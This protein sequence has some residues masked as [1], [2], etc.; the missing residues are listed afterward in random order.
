MK[1]ERA[2]S[3]LLPLFAFII[4]NILMLE[5]ASL[6][7]LVLGRAVSNDFTKIIRP[8]KRGG[9]GDGTGESFDIVAC[10]SLVL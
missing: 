6:L 9:G 4:Y 10:P 7:F 3:T 8:K 2:S 5:A 1:Y